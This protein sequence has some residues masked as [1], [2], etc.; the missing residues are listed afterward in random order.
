MTQVFDPETGNVDAVTVIEAGPCPVVTVRTERPTATTPSSSRSSR[1]ST[2]SSRRASSAISRKAGVGGAPASG[3]VPRRE[4]ARSVGE[5]RHGRDVRARRPHQGLGNLDRQ[6]LP[7]HD[8]AAQL[9]TAGPM[10]HGS[11]NVRKPGLD[12]RVGHPVARVQGQ[13]DGR[14]HGCAARHPAR[15]RR[16]RRGRRAESPARPRRRAR[17]EE[18]ARRDPGG[19]ALMAVKATCSAARRRT[20]HSTRRS[21][22]P[23]SSRTSSTRPCAPS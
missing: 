19:G 6:G 8:Q 14:P 21:S 12:R 13:E 17:P 1:S 22:R 23:R 3:R 2:G 4:R 15:T 18:R 5:T 20:S 7:G 9:R 11:H 16:T 10:S